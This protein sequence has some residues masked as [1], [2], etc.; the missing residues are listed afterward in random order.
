MPALED[1]SEKYVRTAYVF[2]V[3]KKDEE[4]GYITTSAHRSR[5]P[6]L[7]YST[8]TSPTQK[9]VSAEATVAQQAD[10]SAGHPIYTGG[11]AYG[12][13][14]GG[15]QVLN[16]QDGSVSHLRAGS[17]GELQFTGTD[18][19]HRWELVQD[20]TYGE[21]R[22]Y[23]TE[24]ISPTDGNLAGVPVWTETDSGNADST[25]IG[26]GADS[27]N[28]WDGCTPISAS[29]I[30]GFHENVYSWQDD[31]RESIIDRLHQKMETNVGGSTPPLELV[32]N[33][34]GNVSGPGDLVAS[35]MVDG[36]EDYT[37]GDN[38]YSASQHINT[39]LE[40]VM[41]ETEQDSRPF[42]LNLTGGGRVEDYPPDE[43]TYDQH[44]VCVVGYNND[45]TD[46]VA[47]LEIHDTWDSSEHILSYGNWF[48]HS[49]ITVSAD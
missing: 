43:D 19:E 25:S 18:S 41:S 29:M 33:L 9:L 6:V 10:L 4:V 44:S 37:E 30:I 7:E 11:I 31:E 47:E 1:A 24:G 35:P 36:I 17:P 26:T 40:F 13:E 45:G 49:S 14:V 16:V 42:M 21:D 39:G 20:G 5:E 23:G 34:D 27:W 15:S 12:L 32:L 2:P 22:T 38:D 46:I 8:G 28:K 48:A 3:R